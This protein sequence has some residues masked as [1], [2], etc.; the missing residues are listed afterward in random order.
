MIRARDAIDTARGFLGR[1]YSEMD[2]I[3]LIVQIIRT[4]P[5]GMPDYR[6]QGTN[7]LWESVSNSGKYRH[8]TWQQEGISGAQAGMLAF[9]RYGM[10]DEGHVGLVT[11]A[12]TVIHASSVE[13]TTVETLLSASQGWDLLGIHRYIGTQG[14]KRMSRLYRAKVATRKDPLSLRAAPKDGRVIARIAKGAIVDVMSEDSWPLIEYEGM[15]GYASMAYLERIEEE[16]AEEMRLVLT[17]EAGNTWIPDGGFS[18][19]LRKTED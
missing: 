15:R 13:G 7:W 11:D 17:D 10:E 5:G 8:L 14:A 4:S 12:G 1:P 2:C 9:K 3:A 6:C 19:Q 16:T 18:A